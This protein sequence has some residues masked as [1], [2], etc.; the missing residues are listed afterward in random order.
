[1]IWIPSKFDVNSIECD[2]QFIQSQV[3]H[4]VTGRKFT[5]SL[6]NGYDDAKQKE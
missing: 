1:M 5:I 6:I 2:A 4:L 3:C